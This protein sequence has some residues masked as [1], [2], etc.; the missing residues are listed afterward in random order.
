MNHLLSYNQMK[1]IYGKDDKQVAE[2]KRHLDAISIGPDG[3]V[4]YSNYDLEAFKRL[5][6]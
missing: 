6:A 5:E 1:A 3:T 4:A 2:I